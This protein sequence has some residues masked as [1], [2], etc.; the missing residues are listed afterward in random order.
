MNSCVPIICSFFLG[1]RVA[2]LDPSIN[3]NDA[4]DVLTQ[5]RPRIIFVTPDVVELIDRAL[6]QIGVD[7]F[8]VLFGSS[9]VYIEFDEFLE[10]VGG[11]KYFH[12]LP[13]LNL[14]E[15]ALILF[16]KGQTDKYKGVCLSHYA[17]LNQ[18]INTISSFNFASRKTRKRFSMVLSFTNIANYSEI[19][20]VCCCMIAGITKIICK[21]FDPTITWA[22][23]DK[24]DV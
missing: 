12:P 4:V 5:I 7:C 8:I 22:T 18:F 16:T 24:Y 2:L 17:L 1:V 3:F 15:T 10:P 19:E 14:Q 9:D 20:L 11:E 13:I 21:K 23:I 6:H